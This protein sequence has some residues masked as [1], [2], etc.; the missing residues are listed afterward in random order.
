M[1]PRNALLRRKD[2]SVCKNLEDKLSEYTVHQLA[3]LAARF[4]VVVGKDRSKARLVSIISSC[5]TQNK[6]CMYVCM[7]VIY[8]CMYVF[9]YGMH[10]WYVCMYVCMC[11][12]MYV[13]S[14]DPDTLFTIMRTP[15]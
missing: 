6:V 13:C 11:A 1:I 12:C 8:A 10:V 7:C 3:D 15:H 2:K 5:I 14:D 4:G 9:V